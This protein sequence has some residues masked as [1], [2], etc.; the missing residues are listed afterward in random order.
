M[1]EYQKLHM[2]SERCPPELV[3]VF[4]HLGVMSSTQ[5]RL[6][7][8]VSHSPPQMWES[9]HVGRELF[10]IG[11]SV[12]LGFCWFNNSSQCCA[13]ELRFLSTLKACREIKGS[14]LNK[15]VKNSIQIKAAYAGQRL[16]NPTL[17]DPFWPA[18]TATR[19]LC[20]SNPGQL[21]NPQK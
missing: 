19:P 17:A 16:P 11:F 4:E 7:N 8:P 6:L 13:E 9:V 3:I 14:T 15:K 18:L 20:P 5:S 2:I 10:K 21:W 12:Q 1:F